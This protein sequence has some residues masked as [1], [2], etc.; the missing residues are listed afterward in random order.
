MDYYEKEFY[1][2]YEIIRKADDYVDNPRQT[3]DNLFKFIGGTRSMSCPE[4]HDYE[5]T[6]NTWVEVANF[7]GTKFKPEQDKSAH[8]WVEKNLFYFNIYFY[9]HGN[10]SFHFRKTDPWDSGYFGVL[11]VKYE[12][13]FKKFNVDKM[14]DDILKELQEQAR[15]ELDEYEA[16]INGDYE[17]FIVNRDGKFISAIGG[18]L[19]EDVDENMALLK[20]QIDR[21][22]ELREQASVDKLKELI[23]DKTPVEKI[24]AMLREVY[25]EEPCELF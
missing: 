7:F 24:P 13:L 15:K 9:S 5:I 8:A 16:Y 2:G 25:N 12:T 4:N 17:M 6:G 1:K 22:V 21:N 20:R 11:A 23:A 3:G 18:F 14:N 19:S 10:V